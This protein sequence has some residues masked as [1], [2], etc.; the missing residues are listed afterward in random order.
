MN[1]F[2]DDELQDLGRMAR[3]RADV[4]RLDAERQKGTSMASGI[5]SKQAE[6]YDQLATKCEQMRKPTTPDNVVRL[7]P[8]ADHVCNKDGETV[9]VISYEPT[10]SICGAPQVFD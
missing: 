6:H 2:T 1:A 10:C 3:S 8:G 5:A 7:K 9:E 4:A